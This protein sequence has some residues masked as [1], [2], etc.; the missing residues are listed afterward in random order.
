MG[1]FEFFMNLLEKVLHRFWGSYQIW[2]TM[3][4][5]LPYMVILVKNDTFLSGFVVFFSCL[6]AADSVGRHA[7]TKKIGQTTG[8]LTR[9]M[10]YAYINT[11]T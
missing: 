4:R 3:V 9:R 2:Y 1:F 11:V 5:G 8:S 10:L 7:K 6:S